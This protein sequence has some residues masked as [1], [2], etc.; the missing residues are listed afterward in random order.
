MLLHCKALPLLVMPASHSLAFFWMLLAWVHYYYRGYIM[1]RSNCLTSFALSGWH[2]AVR[3]NFLFYSVHLC[4][5]GLRVIQEHGPFL[6]LFT[7]CLIRNTAFPIQPYNFVPGALLVY[8]FLSLWSH[9][10]VS[11]QQGGLTFYFLILVLI[12]IVLVKVL[13]KQQKQ[14]KKM[15]ICCICLY[16]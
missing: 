9:H 14:Y 13:L 7:S 15:D 16:N 10:H 2:H 5:Y 6:S 1:H 11:S 4:Q 12:S 3:K 8:M